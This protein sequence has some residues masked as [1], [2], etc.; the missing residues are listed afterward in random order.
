MAIQSKYPVALPPDTI[1]AGQYIVEEVLGQGGFGITYRV[2]DYKTKMPFAVKE[3]F[4]EGFAFRNSGR[5][6][7][8]YSGDRKEIFEYSKKSFLEEAKTLAKFIGYNG[9]VRIYSYF[10]ENGTAYFVMDYIHGQN[11]DRYIRKHGNRISVED[12]LKKILPVLDTLGIVHNQGL[13]HRDISPDNIYIRNDG[14]VILLDFGA[15]RYSFGR[16][17]RMLDVILKPGYAPKEQYS[18]SGKLGPYTDIYSLAATFYRAITGSVPQE[19]LERLEDDRLFP[20][21]YLGI[22]I[23]PT[24]E[25]ALMRALSIQ[26]QDRFQSV[27]DF[28]A[29]LLQDEF[30]GSTYH[31]FDPNRINE[32]MPTQYPD[33][34]ITTQYIN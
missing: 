16:K 3:F 15:A 26:P 24:K 18:R 33:Y 17:S 13:I 4:P 19:S 8:P 30:P 14:A 32:G 34:E 31:S 28:K 25:N 22:E 6:V 21:H 29:A 10:E 27:S 20:P 7:L 12:A 9:I 23:S 1:L 11:F 2:R 5:F